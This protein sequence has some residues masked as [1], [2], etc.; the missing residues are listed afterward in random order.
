MTEATSN[1]TMERMRTLEESL[2]FAHDYEN[3]KR[4]AFEMIKK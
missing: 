2:N 3:T 1:R 4:N